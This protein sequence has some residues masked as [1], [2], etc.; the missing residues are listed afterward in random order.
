MYVIC[1][2]WEVFT[3]CRP[4]SILALNHSSK[5]A[6]GGRY[7]NCYILRSIMHHPHAFIS[8]SLFL[9]EFILHHSKPTATL[10]QRQ[11]HLHVFQPSAC[12]LHCTRTLIYSL[13]REKKRE[14]NVSSFAV[15]HAL[16]IVHVLTK[17][18]ESLIWFILALSD[19]DMLSSLN[20]TAYTIAN[21]VGKRD[22]KQL[23]VDL[24]FSIS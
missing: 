3:R 21:T 9:L 15:E 22:R 14:S 17:D 5:C 6:I 20:C 13:F 7:I 10:L 23:Q 2:V 4:T 19:C 1:L 12:L 16:S 18:N 8:H 11:S 24:C